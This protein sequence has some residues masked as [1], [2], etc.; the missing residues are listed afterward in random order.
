[1]GNGKIKPLHLYLI[2]IAAVII[3]IF[4]VNQVNHQLPEPE[5]SNEEMQEGMKDFHKNHPDMNSIR[6]EFKKKLDDMKKYVEE[7]PNDTAKIRE[8]AGLLA[9]AHRVDE[10]VVLFEKILSVDGK[11]VDVLMELGLVYFNQRNFDKADET[12]MKVLSLVPDNSQ[13]YFNRGAIAAAKGDKE[14]AK[15][16]WEK[17]IEEFPGSEAAGYAKAA[18]TKL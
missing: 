5:A 15:E 10:A 17:V 16:L 11:R 13:A 4:S 9:S 7:N 14:K 3:V 6:P 12:M 18:L 8:Y 1:M 2:G